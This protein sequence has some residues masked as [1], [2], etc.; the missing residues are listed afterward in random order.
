MEKQPRSSEEIDLLYF[1]NPVIKGVN[2]YV[3]KLRKGIF[4]FAA[5]FLVCVAIG[6]TLRFFLP[7]YFR[8]NAIFVSY[9]PADFSSS[10]IDD[11]QD[12]I[13]NKGNV[14]VL[15]EQLKIPLASASSI[16]SVSTE[17]MDS[18]SYMNV[19]D[20]TAS[21][22]KVYLTVSDPNSIPIF[23]KG[24]KSFLE[25]NEYS[26]KRK[27]AKRQTLEALKNDFIEKVKGLDSLKNI[28]NTTIVPRSNGQGVI[29]G[30]PISPIDAYEMMQKF[31]AGQKEIEEQLTLLENIEILQPFLKINASNY[32]DYNK[33]FLYSILIGLAMALILTPL[34]I[35]PKN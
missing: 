14:S 6:Y 32:P 2:R 30:E 13:D 1:F 17:V 15:A 19:R 24:L 33:I 18:L 23:Q 22:F 3:N 29:L 21:A 7:K 10:M 20:T 27:E 34:M 9:L 16:K 25:N 8:T 12:L 26:L 4:L 28:L 5:I 31:Y 11:L 35:K